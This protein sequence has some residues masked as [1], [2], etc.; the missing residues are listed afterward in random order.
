LKLREDS[1][2]RIVSETENENTNPG[3][4]RRIEDFQ[5]LMKVSLVEKK[6]R[7]VIL[8]GRESYYLY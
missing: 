3:R 7:F 6:F 1:E 8:I 4:M 2:A 5:N